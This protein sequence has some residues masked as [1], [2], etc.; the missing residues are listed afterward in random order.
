[1][2]VAHRLGGGR[3]VK[4]GKPVRLVRRLL[5]LVIIRTVLWRLCNLVHVRILLHFGML[6][7][8][9]FQ[10][11]DFKEYVDMAYHLRSVCQLVY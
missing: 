11:E 3:C 1:M 5:W 2:L 6:V 7:D 10:R 9:H 4:P 8:F